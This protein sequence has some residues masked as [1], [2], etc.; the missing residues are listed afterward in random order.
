MESFLGGAVY[1]LYPL[2]VVLAAV[3]II[4]TLYLLA[5]VN[6][7]FTI[8]HEGTAKVVKKFGK[9]ERCLM[10]YHEHKFDEKWNVVDGN[11]TPHHFGG[12]RWVGIPFIYSVHESRFTW[13]SLEQVKTQGGGTEDKMVTADEYLDYTLVQED[14]YVSRIEKVETAELVPVDVILLM[15]VA[16]KNPRKALF[17][18]Q[19]WLEATQNQ[20][21]PTVREFVGTQQYEQLIKEKAAAG[22]KI[23]K[24]TEVPRK[25]ILD[26]YGVEIITIQ[27]YTIEPSSDAT[28]GI[29]FV[30]LATKKY[31]AQREKESRIILAKARAQEIKI[32]AEELRKQ[33]EEGK[34]LV[35]LDTLKN[36]DN[37]TLISRPE[38]AV[39]TVSLEK[40]PRKAEGG[41]K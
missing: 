13:T 23:S 11:D 18:V 14:V 41:E 16:I 39:Y 17:D 6:L 33:G 40:P 20:I 24:S 25:R 22:D 9:F 1:G 12:L 10:S 3:G 37:L 27:V 26:E 32:P 34:L 2:A 7:F 29:D 8:V 21:R 28:K 15:T 38:D 5:E 35:Q 36:V 31:A 19:H 30:A 4:A